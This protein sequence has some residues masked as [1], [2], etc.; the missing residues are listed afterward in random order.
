MK[1]LKFKDPETKEECRGVIHSSS[2][3]TLDTMVR[4]AKIRGVIHKDVYGHTH[5]VVG[6]FTV[7]SESGR[8]YT[9]GHMDAEWLTEDE[10]K[11]LNF[12][13]PIQF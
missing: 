11:D 7:I 3:I 4:P 10:I 9:V 2:Y 6:V 8:V 13:F 5:N 1:Y 12:Q